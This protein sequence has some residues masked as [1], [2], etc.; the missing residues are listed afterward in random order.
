VPRTGAWCKGSTPA[1]G[2]VDLGSNPGAPAFYSSF[3][4]IEMSLKINQN[5]FRGF[6][7]R[8]VVGDD[9]DSTSIKNIG[10]AIGEWFNKRAARLLV[11]GYDV[12]VTSPE[13]HAHLCRGLL[14]SGLDVFDIGLTPTPILNFATDYYS[15]DGGVMVTASHNPA[16]YNGLKIRGERT[17]FGADLQEI[18]QLAVS[19]QFLRNPGTLVSQS[20]LQS[21]IQALS[22]R[23]SYR[24]PL[25]VVVD[26]G[27]GANGQ[28]V[29]NLLRSFG[30]EVI[31]LFCEA[32][33]NFP[34]RN[35]DPTAAHATDKLSAVVL[36]EKADVGLAFDGD[37]DRVI[38]VDELGK[39]ILGDEVLML[40]AG[41]AL[42][43]GEVDRIVYEVLCSHAVPDYIAMQGGS[44]IPAPSG[45][46][47]VHDVMLSTNARIGGEMSGHFFLIDEDFKFDDAILA[48]CHVLTLISASKI[49]LSKMVSLL[50]KYFASKEYRMEC[51]REKGDRYKTEIVNAVREHYVTEG[52]P[53]E[54]ID[55][56][57]IDFGNAWALVRQSNTEPVISL[58]FESRESDAHMKE[59]RSKV[60][61]QVAREF[62]K[63][64]IPWSADL[65]D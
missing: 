40:L 30:H 22:E 59:I 5:S 33:G 8:G 60:F 26:G 63:R 39:R 50:P 25:R 9:F 24:R 36:A 44:P 28:V 27:N 35:P 56:V 41:H 20:P 38:L 11:T 62:D 48:A 2:A 53:L 12:R 16:H 7:I 18:Y 43:T 45:Y 1:F 29:P 51:G 58:R 47:F 61:S 32:D 52:Y 3:G 49:S 37:G 31:E 19:E 23:V 46:A 42:A 34:N 57:A 10:Y 65:V 4:R 55:G 54:T 15:A 14:A 6:S 64:D 17:V 21:Y 13:M